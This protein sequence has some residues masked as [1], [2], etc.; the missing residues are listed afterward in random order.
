MD[1][2]R[3]S[4]NGC[5]CPDD[6][7]QCWAH[8]NLKLA[9][10][11][12]KQKREVHGPLKG[13]NDALSMYIPYIRITASTHRHLA[14]RD[15]QL[16]MRW[17]LERRRQGGQDCK[18]GLGDGASAIAGDRSRGAVTGKNRRGSGRHI[19]TLVCASE[20]ASQC[21]DGYRN[22]IVLNGRGLRT[23]SCK[24]TTY[25]FSGCYP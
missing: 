5:F 8:R 4:L 1:S 22:L 18:E 16:F 19:D 17:M 23:R 10:T 3:P 14:W 11:L 25:S 2:Q 13:G 12:Q 9:L 6:Y 21:V 20:G 15:D 7:W 24:V